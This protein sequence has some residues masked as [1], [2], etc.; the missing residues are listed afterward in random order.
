MRDALSDSEKFAIVSLYELFESGNI[1]I[2]AGMDKIQVVACRCCHRELCRVYGRLHLIAPSGIAKGIVILN[3][4]PVSLLPSRWITPPCSS[5]IFFAIAR[6]NPQLSAFPWLTKGWKT[7]SR[8]AGGM[9][10]P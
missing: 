4:V 7:E 2:F 3:R 8:I 1:S 6:P 10:G 9:P 5:T